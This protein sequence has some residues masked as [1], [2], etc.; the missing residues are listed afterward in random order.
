MKLTNANYFSQRANREYYSVSQW[1]SFKKC[2]NMAMAEIRGKYVREETTALLVGS[3]V[4]AY[5]D[6]ELEKFKAEAN[7]GKGLKVQNWMRPVFQFVVPVGILVVYI[8]GL[9]TFNW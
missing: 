8:M 4:D 5:F 1:K 6:N 2:S 9:V 7:S 3:Y